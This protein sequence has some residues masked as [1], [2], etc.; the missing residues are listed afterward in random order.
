VAVRPVDE[1][2]GEGGPRVRPTPTQRRPL[3]RA[4][5]VPGDRDLRTGTLEE[6]EE[7]EGAGPTREQVVKDRKRLRDFETEEDAR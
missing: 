4:E 3:D 5:A 1:G 7:V 6:D 2:I